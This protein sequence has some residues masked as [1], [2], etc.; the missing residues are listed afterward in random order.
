[1]LR[2]QLEKL[3][4][5]L[6]FADGVIV[7]LEVGMSIREP[8]TASKATAFGLRALASQYVQYSPFYRSRILALACTIQG[9]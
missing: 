4:T 6:D 5:R 9:G 1:M 8:S 3:N 2:Q 7:S